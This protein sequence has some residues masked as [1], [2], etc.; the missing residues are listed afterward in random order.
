MTEYPEPDDMEKLEREKAL[1]GFYISGHPLDDYKEAW[2]KMATL[3]LSKRD[4]APDGEYTVIGILKQIKPFVTK[5]GKKMAFG[6]LADYR[7]ELELVFFDRVWTDIADKIKTEDK[8]ALKGK[9]DHSRNRISFC[10]GKLLD[11]DRL[12]KKAAKLP[13]RPEETPSPPAAAPPAEMP[14]E[15]KPALHIRLDKTAANNAEQLYP[16]RALLSRQEG[17]C[18]VYLHI[19]LAEGEKVI[20]TSAAMTASSDTEYLTRLK[21]VIAVDDAWLAAG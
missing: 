20:R 19:P 12:A 1:L 2:Q 10:V 17:P 15:P 8:V 4:T 13:D 18:S 21:K 7:G 3:D 11:I 9:L 5:A 14:P 16:L 6:Q